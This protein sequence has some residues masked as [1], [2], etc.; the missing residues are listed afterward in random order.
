[1][2]A[3]LLQHAAVTYWQAINTPL[4]NVSVHIERQSNY[5]EV[6]KLSPG[7][8]YAGLSGVRES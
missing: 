4:Q 6:W 1:M 3:A 7:C 2:D 8:H 5:R